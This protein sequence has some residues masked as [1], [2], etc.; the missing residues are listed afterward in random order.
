[1]ST[2]TKPSA[3]ELAASLRRTYVIKTHPGYERE[4]IELSKEK[5]LA[6]ASELERLADLEAAIRKLEAAKETN[7]GIEFG[8]KYVPVEDAY[9]ALLAA[10]GEAQ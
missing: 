10:L 3:R 8:F 7:E 4:H 6:I 5:A 1:M 9:M 2:E